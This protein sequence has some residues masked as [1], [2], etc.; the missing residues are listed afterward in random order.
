MASKR[1]LRSI[2]KKPAQ[3]QEEEPM[4]MSPDST[5]KSQHSTCSKR[6]KKKT[7]TKASSP[8]HSD[9]SKSPE[10]NCSIC[11]GK[12]EN[13][14]FT[15][16]CFH[17]F[18]FVCIMEWSKV[19]ATC[20]L[21]KTSFKSIIHNIKSNE[22]Y[23]QYFLSSSRSNTLSD[24]I[25]R[26]R[27]RYST[28]LASVRDRALAQ[29]RRQLP[30]TRAN[31]RA[32][33]E[34]REAA[35][36]ERR[37]Q[38]YA[39]G[40]R[41]QTE[42]SM[43]RTCYRDISST[44][45]QQ[46][47]ACLH[48]LVPW[49]RR[50]LNVLFQNNEDLVMF[51]INLILSYIPVMDMEGPE[52]FDNLRPFMYHR[53][54]QFIRELVNFARSPYDMNGYDQHTQYDFLSNHQSPESPVSARHQTNSRSVPL[55]DLSDVSSDSSDGVM[56]LAL[57]YSG[58]TSV[59]TIT[60]DDQPSTSSM[61]VKNEL[62]E[63]HN[64]EPPS[65][66]DSSD[67]VMFVGFV[68]SISE[69]SPDAIIT[70]SSDSDKEGKN[71]REI[72]KTVKSKQKLKNSEKSTS[73]SRKGR[74]R[75]KRDRS[76]DRYRSCSSSQDRNRNRSSSHSD[77]SHRNRYLDNRNKPGGKRKRKTK[78]VEAPHYEYVRY[79]GSRGAYTYFSSDSDSDHEPSRN[80]YF[81][82]KSF[83]PTHNRY[84]RSRS[85]SR[86]PLWTSQ[87][88]YR[89]RGRAS[90]HA[91]D[92]DRSSNSSAYSRHSHS[93]VM[94]SYSSSRFQR[95]RGCSRSRS[96]SRSPRSFRRKH[97]HRSSSVEFM[98]SFSRQEPLKD[99]YTLKQKSLYHKK[100]HTTRY[101]SDSDIEVTYERK[102]NH[103]KDKSKKRKKHGKHKR[104]HKH[105]SK[106]HRRDKER[107]RNAET[108][109][110]KLSDTES[111]TTEP[112]ANSENKR[113]IER[114]G[115]S[116]PNSSSED[117]NKEI[118]ID[119]LE[120]TNE[121]QHEDESVGSAVDTN[122]EQLPHEPG[123]SNTAESRIIDEP[124]DAN[125][126]NI[127][128]EP[129][130]TNTAESSITDEPGDSNTAV[131]SITDEPGDSNSAES[132]KADKPGDSDIAVS[133]IAGSNS[134]EQLP[135][136]PGNSN[137]AESSI[138][139]EP[140]D[141]NTAVSSITDEPGDSNS[142]ESSK[143]DEPGDSDI[144]VFSIAGSN[145]GEQLP[146]EP[147][148]TNTTVP[149]IT[150]VPGDTNTAVPSISGFNSGKQLPDKPGDF[151][152]TEPSIAG[153]G[154]DMSSDVLMS[155]QDL[156]MNVLSTT[157]S[158]QNSD[159]IQLHSKDIIA[160]LLGDLSTRTNSD[161]ES[162][163]DSQ[164]GEH[165]PDVTAFDLLVQAERKRLKQLEMSNL[166]SD[167]CDSD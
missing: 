91:H 132:S 62:S 163:K 73:K 20:P 116:G 114:V 59:S 32:Y 121:E 105:K 38:V 128:D 84:S 95:T 126:S 112:A 111:N 107:H 60:T 71:S 158:Q 155:Q 86:S 134:G 35:A 65:D 162:E 129:G 14:S 149:S 140:G 40:L 9:G 3:F 64:P 100:R 131:S 89:S 16:G 138:T 146:G 152:I 102:E 115:S 153:S 160:E 4:D 17:T 98:G 5:P 39:L 99:I 70:L 55:I 23:D 113:E 78:H 118:E 58:H 151:N 109:L 148:N 106:K 120:V 167:A 85:R 87:R 53:T 28:T 21:C 19:K 154:S 127:A 123:D 34:Q 7:S 36:I 83:R 67:E 69:R 22:M 142:A 101:T 46:N 156:S 130:D 157:E 139:D 1:K 166:L 74:T 103:Y 96:R 108:C 57:D 41:A 161:C 66:N 8:T 110:V 43:R 81:S 125:V 6:E 61:A 26:Q 15:D 77:E 37:R 2:R 44:F 30:S 145:S 92:L 97:R 90:Y 47:A 51:M 18:C 72:A 80:Y 133:S 141:S 76:Y 117:K 48:R 159:G 10:N 75:S 31:T 27:F 119:V 164:V 12:F 63:T 165:N 49:L 50:E 45:F 94:S 56:P 82:S 11:L 54:E 25:T 79:H 68:K 13:K 137:T 136:E 52:F 122:G 29:Q 42:S 104:K 150:D 33:R 124:G 144:A 24:E 93:S 135:D 147:G 88:Q 143:A